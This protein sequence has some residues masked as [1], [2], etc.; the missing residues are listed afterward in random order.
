MK[1]KIFIIAILVII[2]VNLA[3]AQENPVLKNTFPV[4]KGKLIVANVWNELKISDLSYETIKTLVNAVETLKKDL[5]NTE[6]ENK[7]A[8]TII[9]EQQK[10]IN[11]MQN[12]INELKRQLAQMNN[13]MRD[14]K[15][16]IK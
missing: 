10:T 9:S 2:S 16:K 11:K 12:D 3:S 6:K 4:S 1:T 8:K 7:N 13:D 5:Q 15:N 14:L